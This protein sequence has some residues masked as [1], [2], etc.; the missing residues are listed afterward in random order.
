MEYNEFKKMMKELRDEVQRF[1]SY[2]TFT[3][4]DAIYLEDTMADYLWFKFGRYNW[5]RAAFLTGVQNAVRNE[6][7]RVC[8]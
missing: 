2:G 8:F 7:L 5:N 4:E 6:I 3:V 1:C